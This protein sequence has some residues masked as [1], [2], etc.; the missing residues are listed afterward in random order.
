MD[1]YSIVTER[2]INLLESGVVP[3]RRPWTSTGLPRNLVSKKPYRGVNF[4]LLSASKYVS[5]FWLTMRQANELDGHVCKGEESTAVVF[6]KIDDVKQSTEGLDNEKSDEKTR[7]RFLLRFYRVWNVQQCELPQGVLDKLPKIETH[8]HDPIEAAERIIADMPNRP[9]IQYTG[10]KAFYSSITDRI[11]L[12]P[13]E[14]FESVEEFYAT[15]DHDLIHACGSPKRLNRE[16]IIEAAPF[17]SAAYSLEELV[18]ELGAAYLCAEAR[19]SNAVIANQAAYVAGWLKKLR[20]D[21]KLLNYAAAQA[22][23]AADYIVNRSCH[24]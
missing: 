21:R 14:L 11:T 10:S 22:Q 24:K 8:E 6:W 3:W 5:P 2:I 4:F 17:G 23:R 9:E 18:A 13:R 19:I 15:L 1:I 20:D 12:P 16:S 7:R